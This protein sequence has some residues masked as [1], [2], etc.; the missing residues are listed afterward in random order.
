MKYIAARIAVILVSRF[1][2]PRPL[3]NPP[4]PP[5]MPSAPPSERCRRIITII[6]KTAMMYMT[7]MT[8][9]IEPEPAGISGISILHDRFSPED[10]DGKCF[11]PRRCLTNVRDV[12]LLG[13]GRAIHLTAGSRARFPGWPHQVRLAASVYRRSQIRGRSMRGTGA[14][15]RL[16]LPHRGFRGLVLLRG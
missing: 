6:E 13:H 12:S 10:Q 2:A 1:A 9:T 8:V 3:T 14:A 7:R 5:P 16:D 4:P 11:S 15:G